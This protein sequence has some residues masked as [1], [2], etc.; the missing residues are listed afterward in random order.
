MHNSWDERTKSHLEGDAPP[1]M[2]LSQM[3]IKLHHITQ[4]L[5]VMQLSEYFHIQM[6]QMKPTF[7]K[8]KK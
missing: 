2:K 5:K 4:L 3:K 7:V 6:C 8:K 1:K